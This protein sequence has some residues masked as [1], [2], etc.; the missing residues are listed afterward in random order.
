MRSR[1]SDRLLSSGVV[2]PGIL[3]SALARQAVYGGALDTALLELDALDEGRLW[4]ALGEATELPIPEPA[5]CESPAKYVNPVGARMI[6]DD[7]WSERC[8]AV[9]VGVQDGMLLLLCGE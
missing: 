9:P 5:F 7:I 6:L 2:E 8:R 3:R 4:Q 1:L